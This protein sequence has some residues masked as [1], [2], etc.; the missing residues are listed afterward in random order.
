MTRTIFHIANFV[1][2]IVLL[3]FVCIA[4]DSVVK[5]SLA[6][7]QDFC[8]EIEQ[9]VALSSSLKTRKICNLVDNFEYAWKQD[10][11]KMCLLVDHKAIEQ[12][13]IEIIRLKNY[14][15]QDEPIEFGVSLQIIEGYTHSY[16]HFM[17]ANWQNII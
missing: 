13:G 12:I 17:G 3:V 8:E 11:E 10:E 9:E 7:V 1:I 6:R 5:S 2:I 4:E 14:I 16:L 15:Y